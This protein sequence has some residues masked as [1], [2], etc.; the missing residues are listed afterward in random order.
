[1][2]DP[3]K[4]SLPQIYAEAEAI[5]VDAQQ[6]FGRLHAAQINWQPHPAAWSVGQCLDHLIIAN[7]EFFPQ[8]EQVAKGVKRTTLWQWMPVLPGLLGRLL[9]KAV[10]PG[11][12][13][14]LKAPPLLQPTLS[15]VDPQIVTRFVSTQHDV[16]ARMR[17]TEQCDPARIIIYSPVTKLIGYS[18]LDAYRILVAHERR[19]FAQAQ[20][21]MEMDAFPA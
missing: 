8:M 16:I 7:R 10:A 20:R 18:L 15:A 3:T 9:I 21:V 1:M 14:K 13:R 4:L 11:A 5:A 12:M 17:A 19:H 6:I 2:T